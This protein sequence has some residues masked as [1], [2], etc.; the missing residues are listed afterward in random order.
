M[1]DNCE[2]LSDV[3]RA[4]KKGND[5]SERKSLVNAGIFLLLF[6][7]VLRLLGVVET[8]YTETKFFVPSCALKKQQI[9]KL[10]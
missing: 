5:Q 2:N 4:I 7:V 1:F 10:S 8:S 3:L 9:I 6:G